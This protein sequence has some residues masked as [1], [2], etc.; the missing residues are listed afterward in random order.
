MK[1]VPKQNESQ[2]PILVVLFGCCIL[3]IYLDG[4]GLPSSQVKST[5]DDLLYIFF[6][7]NA[8]DNDDDGLCFLFCLVTLDV[9]AGLLS[10]TLGQLGSNLR[11]FHYLLA[12][13]A[14]FHG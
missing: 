8:I 10:P 1:V 3:L 13:S 7:N 4:S 5:K 6:N 14:F 2:R 12:T 11:R 9:F